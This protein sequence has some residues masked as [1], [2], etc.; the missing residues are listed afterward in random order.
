MNRFLILGFEYNNGIEYSLIRQKTKDSGNEYAVTVMN[1]ELEKQL[2]GNHVI[3]E[4]DGCLLLD[5][6]GGDE[7]HKLK[8]QITKALGELLGIPLQ[9]IATV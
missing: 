8:E 3:L 1:G 5:N 6:P 9:R 4:K 7:Q 2:F